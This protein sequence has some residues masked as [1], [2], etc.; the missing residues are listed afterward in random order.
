MNAVNSLHLSPTTNLQPAP[1]T[2]SDTIASPPG[3]TSATTTSTLNT[4]QA[5]QQALGDQGNRHNLAQALYTVAQGLPKNADEQAVLAALKNQQMDIHPASSYPQE[6]PQASRRSVSL[7]SFIT[8]SRLALPKTQ[9]HCVYLADAVA[10]KALQHP[11][12]NFGGGLSWPIPLSVEDQ[13]KVGTLVDKNTA[14]LPGLPL[15]D[16]HKGAL[17]Y[18]LSS[19]PLST[20]ELQDPAK[21]LEKLVA[22]PAA[23][24][25]GQAI[26]TQLNGIPTANSVTDYV[27]AAI[28]I[29]LDADSLFVAQR[30]SVAG[31]D[32]AKEQHWGKPA[33]SVVNNLSLHLVS[34][35]K[36]TNA[37]AK[38]ATHLL[39]A[40]TAPQF[41]VKEIPASTVYGSQAWANFCIAVAKVEAEAPGTAAN[42]T[43]AQV[44]KAS[45][46]S[47]AA[48]PES[49]Q[50]AA[51]VDWAVANGIVPKINDDTYTP[52]QLETVRVAFNQQQSERIAAS[53]LLDTP[54]PSRKEIALAKL[55]QEFGDKVP[56]EEKL[57]RLDEPGTPYAEPLYNPN[58]RPAGLHSMLD[59]A[60]M[61]LG[62]ARWKTTDERIPIVAINAP[63]ELEVN[64]TFNDQFKTAIES[65]QTGI[66]T[67][68]KH[69]IAQLPLA[70]RQNLEHGKLEFFQ[71]KT[72]AL[73]LDFTSKTLHDK[74]NKLLV[75]TTGVNGETVYEIDIKK[76]AIT[77][78]SA[79]A[80]TRTRERQANKVEKIELF[81]PSKTSE[82]D[83]SQT[84]QGGS[85]TVPPSF[86]ST[87]TQSI[88][89]V[90]VEHLD[91][92]SEDVVKQAKGASTLDKQKEHEWKVA[93]FF[94][95]LVPL[96]SA[97]VNFQNGNYLDGA[98]DLAMDVFGFVT[99]GVGVAAKV[100]KVGATAASTAA[101][102]V[103][104]AKIIGVGTI[105]AF[106]PAG[107]V[108]DL[109]VGAGRVV[110]GGVKVAARGLGSAGNA[111][112]SLVSDGINKI[113][114]ASGGY[115][116]VEASKR[117]GISATGTF[118]YA[119]KTME[120]S[121]VLQNG[122]WYGYDP[123]SMQPFGTPL[124]EFT[125][126]I[127]AIEGEV[128]GINH[129]IN[130]IG[131]IVAPTPPTQDLALVFE[132]TVGQ[133]K[134]T[135]LDAYNHGYQTGNSD[136]VSGYFPTMSVTQLAELAVLPNRTSEEIGCIVRLME[137]NRIS[138]SIS[139]SKHFS[140]DVRAGGA[141]SEIR[142]MPQGFYLGNFDALNEG[143][144]AALSNAMALAIQYKKEHILIDNLFMTTAKP[145]ALETINF[146][147]RLSAF[148]EVLG[149]NFHGTQT[150]RQVHYQ[151]I[152]SDLA[153]AQTSKTFM[154][155][156]KG[157][158]LVA[159]VTVENNNREW[160]YFN[161]N[162]GLA[163]FKNQQSMEIALERTL[164]SGKSATFAQPYGIDRANPEYKVSE[165]NELELINTTQ[166]IHSLSSLFSKAA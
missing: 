62:D 7:E 141:D 8:Q 134:F 156:D 131:S 146:R 133:A 79:S 73:G 50:K 88:A 160:F 37:T 15:Q 48:A 117:Y 138:T 52:A 35:G 86:S 72:Y 112:L 29:G 149:Y 127:G 85:S 162:Y 130:K 148:Q 120:G 165:F 122:K 63:L 94:L 78:V 163:R 96:R 154:I 166:N 139:N 22:S 104:V 90:F 46:G 132:K 161:P 59:I 13:S 45:G 74:D 118:N 76:G 83:L 114:G 81:T 150:P 155:R 129:F 20:A 159:G 14:D 64:K 123:I 57:L 92:D 101:K 125:P 30:N 44:M 75:K 164:N 158:G 26:Q 77:A 152:I 16:V 10:Q 110:A 47:D 9:N 105:N 28:N 145:D 103:K 107:G 19:T 136:I 97:I 66:G 27:L 17:G 67:T 56:F 144:C 70:D 87:R 11:L 147:S 3:S 102:A 23:Q 39:L 82:S 71:K 124:K 5:L 100:A 108:G 12:G 157:H 135:G 126:K 40:R 34:E 31:F 153:N 24:A 60:M 84:P 89:D 115:D 111:G 106:N 18:L 58:R 143:E 140:I 42:M 119:D 51:L 113:R 65:R 109:L 99:A 69:L 68:I 41:L 128:K 55:K 21:A 151:T 49:A 32:L 33:S 98:T 91:I 53:G 121:A 36:A 137:K 95:N 116:L 4:P 2:T 80:L 93:D 6:T 43:F 142:A 38:L 1:V 61:E 54:I 25:L